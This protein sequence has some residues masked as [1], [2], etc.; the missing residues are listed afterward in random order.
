MS[1]VVADQNSTNCDESCGLPT[2]VDTDLHVW[3]RVDCTIYNTS[4]E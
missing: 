1:S 3:C 2:A 4:S